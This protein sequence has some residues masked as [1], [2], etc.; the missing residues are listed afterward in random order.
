MNKSYNFLRFIQ[1]SV[2]YNKKELFVYVIEKLGIVG[3]C[4]FCIAPEHHCL[5]RLEQ[6]VRKRRIYSDI[7]DSYCILIWSGIILITNTRPIQK[8]GS[9]SL[10]CS[11][12]LRRYIYNMI[13]GLSVI[14]NFRLIEG[15]RSSTARI[16]AL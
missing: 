13:F 5:T 16:F 8:I 2:G 14:T 4:N 7:V 3:A 6:R 9:I 12:Q 10:P 1:C 11:H 15:F